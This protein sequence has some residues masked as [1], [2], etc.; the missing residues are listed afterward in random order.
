MDCANAFHAFAQ[1][2]RFGLSRSIFQCIGK[3]FQSLDQVRRVRTVFVFIDL[4]C[5]AKIRFGFG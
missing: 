4:Y 2:V 1:F 3:P 5:P